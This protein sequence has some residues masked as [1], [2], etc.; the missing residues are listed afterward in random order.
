MYGNEQTAAN[1]GAMMIL[2]GLQLLGLWRGLHRLEALLAPV[3]QRLNR[4]VRPFLPPRTPLQALLFGLL[5]GWLP[6]GLV[7]GMLLWAMLQA[8]AAQGA[9]LMAVFGASTVP[10]LFAMAWL[11]DKVFTLLPARRLHQ[12]SGVLLLLLG[13]ATIITAG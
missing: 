6:C 10:M 7:Y 4:Y 3:W 9:L 8:D 2:S 1:P 13:A 12:F 5:W 11:G